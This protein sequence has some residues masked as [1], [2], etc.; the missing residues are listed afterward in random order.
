MLWCRRIDE[1]RLTKVVT[2]AEDHRAS[3]KEDGEVNKLNEETQKKKRKREEPAVKPHMT[4]AQKEVD[5]NRLIKR[6]QSSSADHPFNYVIGEDVEVNW[7]KNS[8]YLATIVEQHL[9]GMC[10]ASK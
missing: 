6:R 3:A 10:S 2:P 7:G 5:L 4:H 8:W 9:E 1:I